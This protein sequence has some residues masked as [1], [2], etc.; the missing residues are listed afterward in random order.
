[1]SQRSLFVNAAEAFLKVGENDRALEMLDKCQEVL[2]QKSYPLETI[3]VGFS[4]NDYMVC[5]MISQYYR[6]G[7]PDKA[8]SLAVDLFNELLISARF[9]M[10]YYDF[11]Q[12][13]FELCGQYVYYL[14]DILDS[15]GDKELAKKI[16][17]NFESLMGY[18]TGD[19]GVIPEND[20]LEVA[21][22]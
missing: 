12:S 11:A 5:E 3:P 10:E 17:D 6:L 19:P 7:E 8:R 1:M 13:E 21:G 2:D 22:N 15:A 20:T 9:Y 14:Q 4:G 16:G 18:L